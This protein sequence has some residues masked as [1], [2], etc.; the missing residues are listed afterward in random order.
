MFT[1]P[2]FPTL[3]LFLLILN[4]FLVHLVFDDITHTNTQSTASH[5]HHVT[6]AAIRQHPDSSSSADLSN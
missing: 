2:Q 5:Q 4:R 3:L 1:Q 6:P